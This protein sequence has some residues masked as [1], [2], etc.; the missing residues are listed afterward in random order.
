M[1]DVWVR[2]PPGAFLLRWCSCW[3]GQ[4]P[5][6]RR[7]AGSIP[8]AAAVVHK[9][10]QAN[11]RWQLLRK[12]SSVS[13]VGSTPSPSALSV[14]LA[15]RQRRQP[16]KLERRV[17]FSQGTLMIGDRLTVGHLAL[18]QAAMVRIHLPELQR[19]QSI[20]APGQLLLVVT[21]GSEPG[22]R[23]FDSNPRNFFVLCGGSP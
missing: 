13:F 4:A 2:L 16:S 22:G 23:W 20:T 7:D 12:Q 14:P 1:A 5:V 3:Y 21:P 17:R 15:E 6:K 11:W 8:A 19:N 9:E 10:G 18:N